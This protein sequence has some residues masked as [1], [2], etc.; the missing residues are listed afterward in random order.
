MTTVPIEFPARLLAA[1][2][3][4]PA[5][6]A[7]EVRIAAAIHWYQ[8]GELSQERAAEIAGMGRVEFLFELSRRKIDIIHVDLEE[9]QRE[10]AGE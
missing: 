6:F 10:A 8:Q 1:H 7:R 3:R 2:A 4:T 9:L 5:E